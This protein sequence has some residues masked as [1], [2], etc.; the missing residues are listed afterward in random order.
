VQAFRYWT[1]VASRVLGV[2]LLLWWSPTWMANV[3]GYL[4]QGSWNLFLDPD[5]WRSTAGVGLAAGLLLGSGRLARLL[6]PMP[7]PECPGCGYATSPES[8]RCPECGLNL[9]RAAGA[10]PGR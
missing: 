6:A 7:R 8:E 10:T 4:A 2:L 5:F 9:A 1:T 3:G